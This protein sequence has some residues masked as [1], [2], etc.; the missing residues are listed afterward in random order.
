LLLPLVGLL[1]QTE[2]L[3]MLL[4]ELPAAAAVCVAVT[5]AV[6]VAWVMLSAAA[7]VLA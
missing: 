6:P 5:A 4:Q 2:L 3:L 7:A 1:S